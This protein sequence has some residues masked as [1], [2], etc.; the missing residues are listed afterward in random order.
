MLSL[1]IFRCLAHGQIHDWIFGNFVAIRSWDFP[2]SEYSS[3]SH[4]FTVVWTAQSAQLPMT[5]LEFKMTMISPAACLRF[6]LDDDSIT[7]DALAHELAAIIGLC[8]WWIQGRHGSRHLPS[9]CSSGSIAITM[10]SIRFTGHSLTGIHF[11]H[12]V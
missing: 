8:S 4:T 2:L 6:S 12:G 10:E 5:I 7:H 3:I 9:H 1:L 11:S